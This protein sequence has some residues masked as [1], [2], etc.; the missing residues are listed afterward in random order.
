MKALENFGV[1]RRERHTPS[2]IPLSFTEE[3][4]K[5]SKLGSSAKR[6]A[7]AFLPSSRLPISP[8][9]LPSLV[10][11]SLKHLRS[12]WTILPAIGLLAGCTATD[13]LL[14]HP[15]TPIAQVLQN[16]EVGKTVHFQGKVTQQA[17]FI[18]SGA[19]QLQD[20]T[21]KIWIVTSRELPNVGVERTVRGRVQ[22]HS[23]V[24]QEREFGEVYIEEQ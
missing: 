1:Y 10:T 2:K 13:R 5:G 19:Y 9:P 17:P 8:S 6:L 18:G 15:T 11:L 16:R 21:G 4:S 7:E 24:I 3:D 20:E 23:S 22:Y 14:P 12:Y